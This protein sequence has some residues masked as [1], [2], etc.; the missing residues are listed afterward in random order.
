MKEI[1][2]AKELM[3]EL[4]PNATVFVTFQVAK[5]VGGDGYKWDEAEYTISIISEIVLA[6]EKASTLQLAMDKV[7]EVM[8]K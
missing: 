3:A 8:T 1:I 2:E 6:Q 7:I 4:F 5:Y